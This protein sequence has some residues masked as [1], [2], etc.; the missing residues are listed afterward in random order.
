MTARDH[1][2]AALAGAV[3]GLAGGL[4][5][6]GGGIVLVPMLTGGF[7]L[8]QHQAHGTSLAAIGATA[9]A[10]LVV[11]AS[12]GN[13]AWTTAVP[14]GLASVLTARYGARWAARVS[15]RALA[16]AFAV[17][18]GLVAVRLMWD[19]PA[20]TG[21]ALAHGWTALTLDLGLGA[22]VGL[23]AGSMGVGGGL[24]AVPAFTLLLGMTQQA[25]QGTSLAVI[26]V[27]A[28]AGAVEHARHGN[29]VGR[30]VPGLALGA[31]LGGPLASWF[32]LSLPH[33]V[34]VRVFALFLLA[35][36][37]YGWIR[38]GGPGRG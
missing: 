18:L 13:V 36:A 15:R 8:T 21:V 25:A 7:R 9:L 14:V 27:T 16:R 22:A 12:H 23:L 34:L 20:G 26:L 31:A 19:A 35:N 28:P 2:S 29:V 11:Y 30:L 24:I 10:A 37:T 32:A 4:F 38:A 6:V 3:A 33:E 5:G 1:A 17:F